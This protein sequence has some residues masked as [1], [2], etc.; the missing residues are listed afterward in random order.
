MKTNKSAKKFLWKDKTGR[1]IK[2]TFTISEV[3]KLEVE[4]DEFEDENLSEWAEM[5]EE[6]DELEGRTMKLICTKS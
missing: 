5:A 3:N 2:N 1:G 6:G 4:D